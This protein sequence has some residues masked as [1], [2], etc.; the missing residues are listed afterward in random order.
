[1]KAIDLTQDDE[2]ASR[3][4]KT[5]AKETARR[6]VA[7]PFPTHVLSIM[8]GLV[9]DYQKK[10]AGHNSKKHDDDDK[11]KWVEDRFNELYQENK[12]WFDSHTPEGKKKTWLHVR[13]SFARSIQILINNS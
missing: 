7:S 8:E 11:V 2:T 4:K 5:K 12:E 6:G 1:M 3:T 10:M 9:G 13:K